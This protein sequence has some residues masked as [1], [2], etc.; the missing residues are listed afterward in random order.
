MKESLRLLLSASEGSGL[1]TGHHLAGF[2]DPRVY[3]GFK[4][5]IHDGYWFAQTE[6]AADGP[7]MERLL[8]EALDYVRGERAKGY[9]VNPWPVP[10]AVPGEVEEEL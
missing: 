1:I 10:D 5:T 3:Q 4:L 2:G 8:T 6:L 7:T 9:G